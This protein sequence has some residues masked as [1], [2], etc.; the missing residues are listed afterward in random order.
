MA[1]FTQFGSEPY[2]SY[3]PMRFGTATSGWNF[4]T[5]EED[6]RLI[7]DQTDDGFGIEKD[8]LACRSQDDIIVSW[9]PRWHALDLWGTDGRQVY[10]QTGTD[11]PEK[12]KDAGG[13]Y[14]VWGFCKVSLAR[15]LKFVSMYRA[16][17]N[18]SGTVSSWKQ[19]P[20]LYVSWQV[21]AWCA[22]NILWPLNIQ[23]SRIWRC[24]YVDWIIFGEFVK[25]IAFRP[26]IEWHRPLQG[27]DWRN[28]YHSYRITT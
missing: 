16:S 5:V 4:W 9:L 17:S 13:L 15:S 25:E 19:F 10:V 24:Q 23:P 3:R 2:P 11:L 14:V 7:A 6:G 12:C 27:L 21:P 1:Q 26:G 18:V 28:Y 20:W 8:F 22:A